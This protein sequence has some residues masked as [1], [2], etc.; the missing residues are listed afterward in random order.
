[1]TLDQRIEEYCREYYRHAFWHDD[2]LRSL[3]RTIRPPEALPVLER[4]I[5]RFNPTSRKLR[6][7][8][9]NAY[10]YA[11]EG[12]LEGWDE[13]F[14]RLRGSP[15][16]LKAIEAMERLADRMRAAHYD[17]ARSSGEYSRQARLGAVELEVKSMRG[18]SLYDEAIADT[19]RIKYGIKLS[20]DDL[21]QFVEYLI[22]KDPHYPSW[23]GRILF[24]NCEELFDGRNPTIYILLTD[25]ESFHKAYH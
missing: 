6:S 25:P 12:F 7:R 22:K 17:T 9:L 14:V 3:S 24:K 1:M 5:D 18:I 2:Y 20:G 15:D 4:I 23:S 10:S 21:K 19:L 11:A 16:G 13:K 8:E